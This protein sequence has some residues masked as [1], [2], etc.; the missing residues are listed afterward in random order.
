MDGGCVIPL[1]GNVLVIN[2]HCCVLEA[3]LVGR[4]VSV[5]EHYISINNLSSKGG[6]NMQYQLLPFPKWIHK[7]ATN[8]ICSVENFMFFLG[9]KKVSPYTFFTFSQIFSLNII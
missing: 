8:I 9:K 5:A 4:F 1:L 3:I 2:F 6:V 7:M